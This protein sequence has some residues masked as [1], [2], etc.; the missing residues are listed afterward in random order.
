V[1]LND[2]T[3]ELYCVLSTQVELGD[4]IRERAAG[5]RAKF[6]RGKIPNPLAGEVEERDAEAGARTDV[7]VR[8]VIARML[9][10]K[11]HPAPPRVT[12]VKIRFIEGGGDV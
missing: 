3:P 6:E 11:A 1:A 5:G 4:R 10:P 9:T 8:P 2:C 7:S 12:G